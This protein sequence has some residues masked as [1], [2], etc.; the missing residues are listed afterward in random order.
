[1]AG[2]ADS[3]LRENAAL[4][5]KKKRRLRGV[6]TA[7]MTNFF[8]QI[9]SMQSLLM[10]IG[11]CRRGTRPSSG[12]AWWEILRRYSTRSLCSFA[13][14]QYGSHNLSL[15]LEFSGPPA[16]VRWNELLA[17]HGVSDLTTSSP[18]IEIFVMSLASRFIFVRSTI[19]IWLF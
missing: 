3:T 4:S 12:G 14:A 16:W 15:T 19:R 8:I 9:V 11:P 17:N 1:M 2:P 18:C 5:H 6:G 13:F 7:S 10:L